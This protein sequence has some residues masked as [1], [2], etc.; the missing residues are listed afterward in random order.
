VRLTSLAVTLLLFMATISQAQDPEA[1]RIMPPGERVLQSGIEGISAVVIVEGDGTSVGGKVHSDLRGR[2]RLELGGVLLEVREGAAFSLD[3]GSGRESA[4]AAL[5][6]RRLDLH[7][8]IAYALETRALFD[9]IEM[10]DDSGR[11]W[12][13]RDQGGDQGMVY[14]DDRGRVSGYDATLPDGSGIEVRILEWIRMGDLEVPK[15]VTT[16]DDRGKREWRLNGYREAPMPDAGGN[17][18]ARWKAEES[19]PAEAIDALESERAFNLMA[20]TEGM[21]AAFLQWLLPGATV[22]GP[23]PMTVEERYSSVPD[24]KDQQ[25]GLQWLPEWIVIAGSREL[26]VITGRWELTPVGRDAPADFGQY[27]SIWGRQA[28]TW[29]V[30]ADI[31]TDQPEARPLTPRATGRMIEA[32]APRPMM[33][34]IA[35]QLAELV[36]GEF[37][38]IAFRDGYLAALRAHADRDVIALREGAAA[39]RGPEFLTV[40]DAIA[41]LEPRVEI[42]GSVASAAHD[43]LGVWGVMHFGPGNGGPERLAFLRVWQLETSR[44]QIIADVWLEMP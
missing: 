30:V 11:R 40:P 3:P 27:L 31:G 8:F 22:F 15:R 2:L 34:P 21:K 36:E 17:V 37:Q 23:G 1:F 18:E 10:L 39:A 5:P 26:A 43:F 13:G 28:D 42:E 12:R 38:T 6:A 41:D 32:L 33:L 20:R 14:R 29:R 25:P 24:A 16:V 9:E 4:L 44:W 19:L 7:D 35:D